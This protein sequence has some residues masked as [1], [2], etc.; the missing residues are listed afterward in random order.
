MVFSLSAIHVWGNHLRYSQPTLLRRPARSV[1]MKA[2]SLVSNRSR[3]LQVP[4]TGLDEI[5]PFVQRMASVP[6]SGLHNPF[7]NPDRRVRTGGWGTGCSCGAGR[8]LVRPGLGVFQCFP[9]LL[10]RWLNKS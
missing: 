4:N 2:S 9:D 10:R 6:R 1:H 5:E 7:K 3:H 8:R